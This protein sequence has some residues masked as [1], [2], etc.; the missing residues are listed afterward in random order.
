MQIDSFNLL[1]LPEYEVEVTVLKD[2]NP[3]LDRVK[4]IALELGGVQ[5]LLAYDR[6]RQVG[7]YF[8]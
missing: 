4:R 8:G 3:D 2:G 7:F 5:A 6:P 1:P